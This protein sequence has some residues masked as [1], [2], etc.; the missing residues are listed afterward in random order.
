MSCAVGGS[1]PMWLAPINRPKPSITCGVTG[2]TTGKEEYYDSEK[3]VARHYDWNF[4]T[5]VTDAISALNRI[6][7]ELT[8]IATN[9]EIEERQVQELRIREQMLSQGYGNPFIHHLTFGL[10]PPPSLWGVGEGLW[11]HVGLALVRPDEP[12]RRPSPTSSAP[13]GSA[14]SASVAKPACSLC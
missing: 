6:R 3:Y 10:E 4:R 5:R 11:L 13:S 12:I 14:P 7:R 8:T 1:V 2:N 9:A